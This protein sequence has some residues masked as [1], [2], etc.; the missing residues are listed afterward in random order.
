MNIEIILSPNTIPSIYWMFA[1]S[2]VLVLLDTFT[3]KESKINMIFCLLGLCGIIV[4]SFIS[5]T[6]DNYSITDYN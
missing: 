4:Q 5:I 6:T 2:I 1:L 3:K